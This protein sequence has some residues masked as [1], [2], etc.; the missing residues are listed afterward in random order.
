MR[1]AKSKA[2]MVIY[3]V[4]I[5]KM[6]KDGLELFISDNNVVLTKNVPKEYLKRIK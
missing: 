6:K 5:E 4:D 2:L 3:E 1:H